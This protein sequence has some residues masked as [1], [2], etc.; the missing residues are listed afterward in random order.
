MKRTLLVTIIIATFLMSIGQT[1][2]AGQYF[3]GVWGVTSASKIAV[4]GLTLNL[5]REP[6]SINNR[7]LVPVRTVFSQIGAKIDWNESRNRVVITKDNDEIIMY[8]GYTNCYV[9]G[10]IKSM[11]VPAVLFNGT[12]MVPVRFVAEAFNVLVGWSEKSSTVY[13]GKMPQEVIEEIP[14]SGGNASN[15]K[16]RIV[17]IDAGHGGTQTGAVYGGVK[18]KDLNLSIAKKLNAKLK[19]LGIVTYMTRNAD[20]TLSLYARSDLANRNNAD[21]LIS[22]HNNAGLL[23]HTG[24]MTL[25]YPS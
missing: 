6:V 9:N 25:Y 5:E 15:I 12:V 19:E 8:I 17:V 1:F 20:T 3:S 24:S 10:A 14:A 21:L 2:A 18:E 11:E 16:G 13:L 7:L 4:S 22:I 23:K